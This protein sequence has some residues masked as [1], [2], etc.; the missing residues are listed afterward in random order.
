MTLNE[1]KQ[2]Q[3]IV[4]YEWIERRF[5]LGCPTEV[6]KKKRGKRLQ[7]VS[8]DLNDERG[9]AFDHP[10]HD[11][12]QN[13]ADLEGLLDNNWK[14]MDTVVESENGLQMSRKINRG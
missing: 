8:F 3:D 4:I 2:K 10:D 9:I 1:L 12:E 7:I 11:N 13:Y 5:K 6:W 14:K